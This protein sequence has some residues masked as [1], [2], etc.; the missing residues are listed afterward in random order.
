M[1]THTFAE[2]MLLCAISLVGAGGLV[3]LPVYNGLIGESAASE[4]L[5]S[6][7]RELRTACM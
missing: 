5:V 6:D 4:T 7:E 2:Q 1:A 3:K